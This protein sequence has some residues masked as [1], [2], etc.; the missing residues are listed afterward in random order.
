MILTGRRD[1][2]VAVGS[3]VTVSVGGGG[4]GGVD[5]SVT[6]AAAWAFS[7][8]AKR[9]Q[10]PSVPVIAMAVIAICISFQLLPGLGA[11]L[12]ILYYSAG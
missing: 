8:V 9:F 5:V 2:A 1:N 10:N 4:G 6:F 3:T 11:I 12:I 7:G